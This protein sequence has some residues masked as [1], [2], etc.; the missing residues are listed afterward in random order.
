MNEL[1][2][3]YIRLW[4]L[5]R[6]VVCC[7]VLQCVAVCCH[8]RV[9]VMRYWRVASYQVTTHTVMS[10]FLLALI[11]GCCRVQYMAVCCSVLQ[12]V[13]ECV[14]ECG[15]V[16][17]S[18]LQSV[19]CIIR[20]RPLYSSP[21]TFLLLSLLTHVIIFPYSVAPNSRNTFMTSSFLYCLAIARGVR[22]PCNTSEQRH[23]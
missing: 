11:C 19:D 14:A 1:W 15:A 7:S 10:R 16:R 8:S 13:V 17:C 9:W 22:L 3:P 5:Q 4:V 2:P 12:C 23:E 21:Q 20:P 18:A 6:V